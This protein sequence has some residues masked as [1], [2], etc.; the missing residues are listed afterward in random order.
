MPVD[1]RQTLSLRME[2]L[3]TGVMKR[4]GSFPEEVNPFA[5]TAAL[6]FASGSGKSRIQ[7][8]AAYLHEIVKLARIGIE[9][10]W[11]LAGQHLPTAHLGLQLPELDNASHQD[12]LQQLGISADKIGTVRDCVKQWQNPPR[13]AVG[14]PAPEFLRGKGD[15]G[16]GD[17]RTVYWSGGWMENH[18]IRDYAKVIRIGFRGIRREIEQAMTGLD[19]GAPDYAHAENFWLAALDICDAGILLGRR[20]AEAARRL[21]DSA[22]SPQERMRL[23]GIADRCSRVP[24]EGA[25]TFAEAVQSLWLAHI[26]T[27]GEDGI[28]AN[29]LGRLD[30]ILYPCYAAD[31]A[32]GR[33]DRQGAVELME[34]FGCRLYLEYDVQAIT[35]GGVNHAGEDAVNDLSYVILD[36]TRNLGFIRDLS[37]RLH[38]QS[39]PAFVQRASEL[40]ARGGGIPSIFNDECF[41]PALA[42]RGIWTTAVRVMNGYGPIFARCTTPEERSAC[43]VRSFRGLTTVPIISKGLPRSRNRCPT[44]KGWNF[45]R[46]TGS[47]KARFADLA[48]IMRPCSG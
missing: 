48:S 18:S 41:I 31:L 12:H 23:E 40:I 4:R 44:W 34:E 22:D 2:R 10:D 28:N 8:R 25:R 32:A 39:P 9:A 26:L 7:V 47:G 42:E 17:S 20:Y 1:S 13:C 19:R 36:A 45:C 21:A 46:T 33:S 30:Q 11:A 29:S 27:C 37:V 6:V 38:R 14:V 5:C 24:A 3:K 35:L 43:A 16:D 15:W